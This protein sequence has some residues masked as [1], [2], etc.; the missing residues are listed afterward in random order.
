MIDHREHRGH[1]GGLDEGAAEDFV[2]GE[3]EDHAELAEEA[4]VE[5]GFGG[6]PGFGDFHGFV[7]AL[8]GGFVFQIFEGLL[9]EAA[10]DASE[11]IGVRV[12]KGGGVAGCGL[13]G[14][15][16]LGAADRVAEVAGV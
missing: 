1:R 6:L 3:I 15:E 4:G 16:L 12:S 8:V 2:G 10:E 9:D 11:E 5:E 13:L 14:E 7:V